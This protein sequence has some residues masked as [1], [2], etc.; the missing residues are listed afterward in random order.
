[1][2]SKFGIGALC[3]AV[4]TLATCQNTV[5]SL[6]IK[7]CSESCIRGGRSMVRFTLGGYNGPEC[8]CNDVVLPK[9][10][11]GTEHIKLGTGEVGM[12]KLNLPSP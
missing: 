9:L 1:M 5:Q 3:I 2:S 12:E 11:G 6:T 7:E 8:V 4:I 10:D